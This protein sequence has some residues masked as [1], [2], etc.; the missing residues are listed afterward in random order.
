[1]TEYPL[2]PACFGAVNRLCRI[3]FVIVLKSEFGIARHNQTVVHVGLTADS[4]EIR[5]CF[6]SH[7]IPDQVIHVRRPDLILSTNIE[8]N[9]IE[10]DLTRAGADLADRFKLEMNVPVR[11]MSRGMRQKLGLIL[12]LA[13][14]PRLLV[15]DEPS[16]S[17][18]PI[19]Q[20]RLY[21]R[22]RTLAAAGHTVFFSSHT[23]SEVEQLC[24]RVAILRDG[25]L[26][27]DETVDDL[28][29]RAGRVVTIRWDESAKGREPDPPAFLRVGRPRQRYN[30]RPSLET[31]RTPGWK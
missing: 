30:T 5:A 26:V 12:A 10:L 29:S 3:D 31:A 2:T 9:G 4:R 6:R 27:A 11:K 25:K 15:L 1:M 22:L 18:D 13:H 19:M 23:L 28:R 21:E 7:K 16:A 14:C 20:E 24:H 8:M 17:L